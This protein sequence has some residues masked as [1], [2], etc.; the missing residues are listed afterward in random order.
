MM[1]RRRTV[2]ETL[3][4][5]VGFHVWIDDG[6]GRDDRS[7]GVLVDEL[8]GFADRIEQ[9][10]ECVETPD[11][12]SKLDASDKVNGDAYVLFADLIQENVLQVELRLVHL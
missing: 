2:I 8:R 1:G 4:F 6:P 9:N 5:A 10:G 12:P 11:D 3:R 7:D